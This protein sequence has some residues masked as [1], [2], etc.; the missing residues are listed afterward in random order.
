MK[1][2]PNGAARVSKRAYGILLAAALAAMIAAAPE[3][4][5]LAQGFANPPFNAR[6]RCYWIWLN[7]NTNEKTITRDLEALKAKGLA[8]G[9]LMDEGMGKEQLTTKPIPVGPPFG[10]PRWRALFAHALRES[11]RLG[12]EWSLNIQSGWNLGG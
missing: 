5:T 11:D 4:D 3:P 7:G 9:I 1:A 10:S 2:H 8:G 12:L 6:L